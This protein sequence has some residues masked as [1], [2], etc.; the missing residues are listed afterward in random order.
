MYIR[1]SPPEDYIGAWSANLGQGVNNLKTHPGSG[2]SIKRGSNGV[3]LSLV[4]DLEPVNFT[5]AGPYSFSA[6]YNPG[7][8]V[9]VDADTIYYNE[10]GSVIPFSGE[11]SSVSPPIAAGMFVCTRFVPPLGYDDSMLVNYVI[12]AYTSA[13]QSITGEFADTFRLY[14]YNT[15]YPIY[16]TIPT[17]SLTTA[18]F[19]GVTITSKIN[20]WRPLSLATDNA[21]VWI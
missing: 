5:D 6:S 1:P 13:S 4:N 12:P 8:V 19:A 9:T 21:A 7:D 3:Y 11:S 17:S 18:S 14:S 15:Y 16:P 10:S 2:L 20:F